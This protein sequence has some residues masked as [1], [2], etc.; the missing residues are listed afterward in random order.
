MF[1]FQDEGDVYSSCNSSLAPE[2]VSKDVFIS[3]KLLVQLLYVH[4]IHYAYTLIFVF[5]QVCVCMHMCMCICVSVCL[6]VCQCV[7]CNYFLS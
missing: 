7:A 4:T 6:S 2:N 3:C 5:M 1:Y